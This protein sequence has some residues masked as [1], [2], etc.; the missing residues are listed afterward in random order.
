MEPNLGDLRNN[1][2]L[3]QLLHYRNKNQHRRSTWWGTLCTLK[4]CVHKLIR[5]A[6]D[7]AFVRFRTRCQFMKYYMLPCCHR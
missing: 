1:Y 7:G 2:E 4:A 3:L 6:E 5:E